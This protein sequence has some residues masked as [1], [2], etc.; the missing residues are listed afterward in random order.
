ML[1]LRF[2]DDLLT[3]LV[4]L[5]FS[6]TYRDE[7]FSQYVFVVGLDVYSLVGVP[8][9][10]FFVY[11]SEPNSCGRL[12]HRVHVKP[13]A[14]HVPLSSGSYHPRAIH[15]DD[16]KTGKA[17]QQQKL[18]RFR[19]FLLDPEVL[20]LCKLYKAKA[21]S[22]TAQLAD[23]PSESLVPMKI[24]RLILPYR[25]ELVSLPSELS[26]LWKQWQTCTGRNRDRI[27]HEGLMVSCRPSFEQF[28]HVVG[29]SGGGRLLFFICI[30]ELS[31]ESCLTTSFP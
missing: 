2:R 25:K 15:C 30:R 5:S 6:P 20:E 13:T 1:Y 22:R 12:R 8:F 23:N 10:D 28:A 21:G 18:E 19:W 11:K 7:Q 9:L 31:R 16:A 26:L 3:V 29:R 4:D 24:C 17:L 14:R 27:R